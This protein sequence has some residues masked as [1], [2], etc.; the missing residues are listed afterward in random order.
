MRPRGSSLLE[1]KRMGMADREIGWIVDVPQIALRRGRLAR[2]IVPIVPHDPDVR[3]GRGCGRTVLVFDDVVLRQF[4]GRP[5]VPSMPG[6]GGSADG[7]LQD[8][9]WHATRWG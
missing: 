1:A 5:A 4:G 9:R 2:G 7:R 6:T 8:N 3:H